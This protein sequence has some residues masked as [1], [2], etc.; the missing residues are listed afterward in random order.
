[1]FSPDGH[2]LAYESDESGKT[3]VHV[4]AFPPPAFGQGGQWVISTGGGE[5]PNWSRTNHELLYQAGDQIMAVGYS[6]KGGSFVAEKPR[7]WAPSLGGKEWALA[8]DSKRLV[9]M[10][11][12][13]SPETPKTNHE[14]VFLLNFFDELRRKVPLDGK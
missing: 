11:P 8:P 13:E 6:V 4:R 2:W 12:A 10:A 3:E 7:V 1:V 14:V 5:E 9:V